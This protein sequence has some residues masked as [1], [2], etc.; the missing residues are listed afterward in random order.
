MKNEKRQR[1][2]INV[3]TN[4]DK[5]MLMN[6]VVKNALRSLFILNEVVIHKRSL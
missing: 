1:Y 3:S 4:D 2:Y 5:F 6:V